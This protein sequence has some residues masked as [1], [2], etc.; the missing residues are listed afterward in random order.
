VSLNVSSHDVASNI[1]QAL[2]CG[3]DD[4]LQT[5]RAEVTAPGAYRCVCV[6]LKAHHLAVC[7]IAN[8]HLLNDLEQ[9]WTGCCRMC[10]RHVSLS[11]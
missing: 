1:Y 6:E 10:C 4:A 5:V 8:A 9:V 2:L 3:L 11:L 7:A